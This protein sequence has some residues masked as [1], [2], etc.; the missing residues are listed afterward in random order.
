MRPAKEIALSAREEEVRALICK[1]LSNKQIAR[2]LG[3]SAGTIKIYV[4]KILLK[5]HLQNRTQVAVAHIP[6]RSK[7]DNLKRLTPV[8]PKIGVWRRSA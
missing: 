6:T 2:Q 7:A 4:G 3:L 8:R 5:M 1:G